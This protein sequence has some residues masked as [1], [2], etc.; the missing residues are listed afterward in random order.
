MFSYN[1]IINLYYF[2]L[3]VN[4]SDTLFSCFVL[5]FVF[6]CAIW[7]K[8]RIILSPNCSLTAELLRNRLAVMWI[9][10]PPRCPV[11]WIM[12]I[13]PVS[14]SFGVELKGLL[15]HYR[16]MSH[17]GGYTFTATSWGLT[18]TYWHLLPDSRMR[19]SS[20]STHTL[21][22]L[23]HD[24]ILACEMSMSAS[25]C[26]CVLMDC[27]LFCPSI[28]PLVKADRAV[29]QSWQEV[30][31]TGVSVLASHPPPTSAFN[32]MF[33]RILHHSL[34][35]KSSRESERKRDKM[36]AYRLSIHINTINSVNA[37]LL[38]FT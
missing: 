12:S 17:A 2:N 9:H 18:D 3:K 28:T 16:L 1:N 31:Q 29:R 36:S 11:S 32:Q 4:L 25:I 27:L 30:Q 10:M 14:L 21:I 26:V 33:C 6:L 13:I 23:A 22:Q 8:K 19:L 38:H 20:S 37:R 7:K 35:W 24:H 15:C 5:F 34:A